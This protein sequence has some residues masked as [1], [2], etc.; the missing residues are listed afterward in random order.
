LDRATTGFNMHGFDSSPPYQG[1][2]MECIGTRFDDV[3]T[4]KWGYINAAS[5]DFNGDWWGY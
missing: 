5:G 4:S 1:F 2:C 3:T